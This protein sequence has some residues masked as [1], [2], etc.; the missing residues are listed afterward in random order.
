MV[1][2]EPFGRYDKDS[3]KHKQFTEANLVKFPVGEQPQMDYMPDEYV[4]PVMVKID[5]VTHRASL[6]TWHTVSNT[7]ISRTSRST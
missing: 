1:T 7:S 5:G 3:M 4:T 2:I 6:T